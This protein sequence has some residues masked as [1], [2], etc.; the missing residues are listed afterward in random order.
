MAKKVLA[1]IK[2]G[3][4]KIN[5][6]HK[7]L[8][9]KTIKRK[10]KGNLFAIVF[11]ICFILG[12]VAVSVLNIKKI[13]N[14]TTF[15]RFSV[16]AME[17]S[18][19]DYKSMVV[20]ESSTGRVLEGY[21]EN[22]RLPMA[23]TTKIATAIV[24]INSCEDINH[25]YPVPRDAVGIEGTSM[26]LKYG[27]R[28]SVRELLYGLML[29]SGNDAA[30]ALAILIGGSEEAFV[31]KMNDLA[32]EL[33]LNDTS[34]KNPHGL[35]DD[36]HY[37]TS[38][39]LAKLTAYAMQ[40]ECFRNIV[41]TKNITIQPREKVGEIRHLKNKQRLIGDEDLKKKDIEVTGAKSG[42]TPEAGRCLVTTATKN[43]MDMVCVLLN[44]P[45]MFESTKEVLLRVGAEYNMHEILRPKTHLGTMN[46]LGSDT[47][48]VNIYCEENFI[49]PLKDEEVGR[50]K[51]ITNYPDSI[52]APVLKNQECGEV[53]IML[54]DEELFRS[55]IKTIEEAKKV[56]FKSIL[57][58]VIKQF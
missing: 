36:E 45:N 24:A 49:Y 53:T 4:Y 37:T 43:D 2:T 33:G 50:I 6:H 11:S 58:K 34:F 25:I 7:R 51:Q 12:L 26:Y 47:K 17:P 9:G 42:F 46:V 20:I 14:Y 10:R 3:E 48:K 23:S 55:T 13:D 38:L 28:F 21:N 16:Q 1:T 32:S 5:T 40:N 41:A 31:K 8:Q 39:D 18:T 35:H 52:V 15:R 29:P 56:G 54:G 44:A 57:D 27:E 22:E 30:T 19:K